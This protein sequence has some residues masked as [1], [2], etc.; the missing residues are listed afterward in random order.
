MQCRVSGFSRPSH[1]EFE[2]FEDDACVRSDVRFLI[3][4]STVLHESPQ[5]N[6]HPVS[7]IVLAVRPA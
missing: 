7:H 1:F 5:H 2:A 6:T 4:A 3:N